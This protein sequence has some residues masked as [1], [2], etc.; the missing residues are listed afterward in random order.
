M[1]ALLRVSNEWGIVV[2]LVI[3]SD[4]GKIPLRG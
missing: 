2:V 4:I 3:S 1:E